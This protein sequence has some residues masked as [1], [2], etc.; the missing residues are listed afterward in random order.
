MKRSD[1]MSLAKS[2]MLFVLI[3]G[4]IS[5]AQRFAYDNENQGNPETQQIET[6]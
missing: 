2:L 3:I 1:A 6:E 4:V 5:C